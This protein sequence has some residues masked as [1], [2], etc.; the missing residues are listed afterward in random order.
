MKPLNLPKPPRPR[1]PWRILVLGA[2]TLPLL[3]VGGW[4]GICMIDRLRA[5]WEV[6]AAVAEVDQADP[7]WTLEEILARRKRIPDKQNGALRIAAIKALLPKEA[8]I[9]ERPA[10]PWH[11]EAD[12][13]KLLEQ[14]R[15]QKA[16][17]ELAQLQDGIT[18]LE[19][20]IALDATQLDY[21]RARHKK[22]DAAFREALQLA[23]FPQGCFAINWLP[24]PLSVK[25]EPAMAA[26]EIIAL[27]EDGVRLRTHDKD[28]Q[29]AFR[30]VRAVLHVAQYADYE[31]GSSFYVLIR[32]AGLYVA[33]SALERILG[34]EQVSPEAL[35]TL[36]RLFEGADRDEP[37]C[38]RNALRGDR[39]FV[40]WVMR[41]YDLGELSLF[42][43]SGSLPDPSIW[44]RL[45][46]YLLDV[47][48]VRRCH[49]LYLRTKLKW[50]RQCDHPLAEQ[51]A[52]AK[53]F[54]GDVFWKMRELLGCSPASD[55][56]KLSESSYRLRAALR[57]TIA[58]AA[59]ERY[60]QE[61]GEWPA[62]LEVLVPGYLKEVPA[63]P[64]D[65]NLLR[66]KR[67][68]DGVV[69]YSVGPDLVDN[70]GT[71]NRQ[72]PD[73]P[74]GDLGFRLWNADQRGQTSP[75]GAK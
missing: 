22:V 33:V 19:P 74:G 40:H 1:C 8:P 38:L 2:V 62:S 55:M 45:K 17:E 29:G 10:I 44:E 9:E 28:I 24:D 27:L 43:R 7:G 23:D 71:L 39:A 30:C 54:E 26:R 70:G 59:A 63:D 50:I 61:K 73:A 34:H 32:R 69:V 68:V 16:A 12:D 47:P 75:V 13:P 5:S 15:R 41:A 49:A 51:S 46:V 67:L 66:L 18:D 64:Y 58:A 25:I 3:A 11:G 53:R 57:C 20:C 42:S 6:Q 31:P 52:L 56:L 60:R 36:Q 35:L 48:A 65:G 14:E 72:Q 21:L 37:A 4:V